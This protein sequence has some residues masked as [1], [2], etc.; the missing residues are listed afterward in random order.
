MPR[1]GTSC[2]EGDLSVGVAEQGSSGGD[3]ERVR[4]GRRPGAEVTL[5][6]QWPVGHMGHRLA[7]C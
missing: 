4:E 5:R 3:G 2:K 7:P 6:L 1:H